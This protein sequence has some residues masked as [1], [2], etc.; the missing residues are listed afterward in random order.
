ML[1]Q[2]GIWANEPVPLCPYPGWRNYT[3]RW[4][5][6]DDQA[7]ERAHEFYLTRFDQF[8]DMQDQRPLPLVQ[9]EPS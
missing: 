3:R 6:P 1:R 8:S 9:L 7:W 2:Q 4:G 5:A